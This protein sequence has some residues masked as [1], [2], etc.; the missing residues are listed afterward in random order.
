[1]KPKC[2]VIFDPA[3]M[4]CLCL[5]ILMPGLRQSPCYAD[6]IKF[7]DRTRVQ[8]GIVTEE[9]ED[10][11]TIR[12]PRESIRSIVRD[13]ERF[14][15]NG[16]NRDIERLQKR[17]ERLEKNLQEGKK[18]NGSRTLDTPKNAADLKQLLREGMGRV[19]GVILS[20]QRPLANKSVIIILDRYAG[21]SFQKVHL[22]NK[23]KSRDNKI[24]IKTKTD[25][26]GQ[27]IFKK[28]P[29]GRYRLYWKP[30]SRTGWVHR[31]REKPDF[32]IS[33]GELVTQNIPE[34]KIN[35]KRSHGR[36]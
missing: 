35:Y 31:M 5:I 29:P 7:K 6:E 14:S 8:V 26:K 17:I 32:D 15:T 3:L 22:E 9:D 10:T 23:K 13:S 36:Y 1:M 4:S 28:V 25:S 20:K 16:K 24:I 19:E 21:L 34:K 27:Y 18:S 12:F 33:A 2:Q 30:D 11:V